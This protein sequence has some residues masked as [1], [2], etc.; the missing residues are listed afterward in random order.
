MMPSSPSHELLA[1]RRAIDGLPGVLLLGDL[2]WSASSQRWVLPC[3]L[4]IESADEQLIPQVSDWYIL[5]APSYPWGAIKF[6]PAKA[7][8]ISRT[9][10][11]QHHNAA[12]DSRI[13]WRTGDLC[14]D[15]TAHAVV[16]DGSEEEPYDS[17]SRL[18]WHCERALDWLR[19]ASRNAL[20]ATGQPFELPHYPRLNTDRVIAF[21]EDVGSFTSWQAI[22]SISGLVDLY[23]IPA[24]KNIAVADLFLGLPDRQSVQIAWGPGIAPENASRVSGLW[25]RLSGPP[26]LPPW[27]SATNWAELIEAVD[28]QGYQLLEILRPLITHIRDGRSHTLLLGFP[29]PELFGGA[30]Q[31]MHWLALELPIVSYGKK[32]ADGFRPNEQGFWNRDKREVF[33]SSK[34]IS[35]IPTENWHSDQ[36]STR[37]RLP[38]SLSEKAVAVIGVGAVGSSM[39]ELLARG[40]VKKLVLVDGDCLTAGNLVRHTLLIENIGDAKARS[41]AERLMLTSPHAVVEAINLN[42]GSVS[43]ADWAKIQSCEVIFDCTGSDEALSDLGMQRDAVER[44]YCSVSIGFGARRLFVFIAQ[45]SAFPHEAFRELIRPWLEREREESRGQE[46]RWSGIGCWHP[47]FPAR[48][49]DL[50]MLTSVALKSIESALVSSPLRMQLAVFEAE[51][52][53]AGFV[54]MKLVAREFVDA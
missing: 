14:L 12:G 44:V 37:G 40:G 29:I 10:P 45:N 54:G 1:A 11:H 26:V 51:Q 25:V 13:P 3:R 49:D 7:G 43:T 32:F 19:A 22:A 24:R 42:L 47:V 46:F 34:L 23:P 17:P 31:C 52:A 48:A 39:A 15:T 35:W 9:F 41:V 4:T 2:A 33:Q 6:H 5:I 16:R 36:L 21:S 8:S 30:P 18:R 20:T 28:R 50:W 27:Q 38:P 53:D